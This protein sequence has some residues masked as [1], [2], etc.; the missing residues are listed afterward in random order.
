MNAKKLLLLLPLL[1]LAGCDDDALCFDS[2]QPE[3][4]SN[5]LPEAI[6]N[7]A[8]DASLRM[9]IAGDP[10]DDAYAYAVTTR[11]ALPDGLLVFASGRDIA[12]I[13][14]PTA[15]GTFNFSLT[16]QVTDPF[17]TQEDLCFDSVTRNFRMVV[18]D[19]GT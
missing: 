5:A 17:S 9:S 3:F 18:A 8:Y 19:P 6:L 14:T 11:G 10:N 1:L 16:M 13:G 12:I 4:S 2:G 7:Q 15:T